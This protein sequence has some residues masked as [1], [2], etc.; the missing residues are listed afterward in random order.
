MSARVDRLLESDVGLRLP[1]DGLR[2]IE[3]SAGTGKT[4]TLAT[5]YLRAL[6]EQRR[7]VPEVLVVTFT[8]AATA[9][10]RLRLRARLVLASRLLAGFRRGAIS[11][12]DDAALEPE[13]RL[14]CAT[15]V[16]ALGDGD[17]A[18]LDRHLSSCLLDLDQAPI[19]TLHG[20]C[21][22]A[23]SEHAFVSGHLLDAGELD[24]DDRERLQEVCDALW[25]E[26]SMES[27]DAGDGRAE[28]M[29]L[30]WSGPEAMAACLRELLSQEA[31]LLP[32][33]QDAPSE[34]SAAQLAAAFARLQ[35]FPEAATEEA[36]ALLAGAMPGLN[37]TSYKP[38]LVAAA[39]RLM[40]IKRALP[41][42]PDDWPRPLHLLGQQYL[43][44]KTNKNGT[45]P[46][47]PLF[48]AVDALAAAVDAHRDSLRQRA[49]R[50]LHELRD[51][52]ASRLAELKRRRRVRSF[53]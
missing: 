42:A 34:R 26:I 53:D 2:L 11:L 44:D 5:L 18:E 40:A 32:A 20:F 15:L 12:D 3:A 21:Q 8:E 37:G 1:L 43:A 29:L 33:A 31:A 51:A 13:H 28:A 9:E 39:W 27:T 46:R 30:L 23:L 16:R 17:A 25:R 45:T 10:L 35:G 52:A 41:M 19:S 36:R 7:R 47:H 50:L 24:G 4:F 6:L 49:I 38:A 48:E 14:V 22:R